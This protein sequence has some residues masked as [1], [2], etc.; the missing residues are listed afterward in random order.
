MNIMGS[1]WEYVL[2]SLIVLIVAIIVGRTLRFLIAKSV[3]GASRK[4]KIVD[5]TKYSLLFTSLHS[6]SFS[7]E[8]RS[9]KFTAPLFLQVQVFWRQLWVLHRSPH[10]QTLSVESSLLSSGLSA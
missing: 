7:T 10:S 9:L 4:L 8:Y 1:I 2:F 5:P 3:K 6:S